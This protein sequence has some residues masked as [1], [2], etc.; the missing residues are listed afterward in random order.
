MNDDELLPDLTENADGSGTPTDER[1]AAALLRDRPTEK[2]LSPVEIAASVTNP[3]GDGTI[4]GDQPLALDDRRIGAR[5]DRR[6]IRAFTEQQPEGGDDHR[7]AR[8]GFAGDGCKTR[9]ERQSRFAD[10]TEVADRDLFDHE[11]WLS[12]P[13]PTS[14]PGPRQPVTGRWNF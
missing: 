8:T 12:S 11:R 5:P 6:G 2:Q 1:A 4:V 13:W 10:D 14:P 7:L 3:I 9:P